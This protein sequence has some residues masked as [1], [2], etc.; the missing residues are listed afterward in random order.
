MAIAGRGRVANLIGENG[1]GD[2]ER[3]GEVTRGGD[4]VLRD[5]HEGDVITFIA[6]VEAFEER[7]GELADGTG[8]FEEA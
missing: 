7:K 6:L 5:A 3:L 2:A 1:K 8:D 4:A